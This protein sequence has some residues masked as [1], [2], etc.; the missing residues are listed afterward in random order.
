MKWKLNIYKNLDLT[1]LFISKLKSL[2]I[3]WET[4][5]LL[6]FY[7]NDLYKIWPTIFISK[8]VISGRV[9]IVGH[10]YSTIEDSKNGMDSIFMNSQNIKIY[11]LMANKVSWS[12]KK[13]QVSRQIHLFLASFRK[14]LLSWSRLKW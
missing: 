9:N 4:Y 8:C 12:R 3:Y 2:Y 14:L 5:Y 7:A 11:K 10:V 1:C 13:S 6:Y